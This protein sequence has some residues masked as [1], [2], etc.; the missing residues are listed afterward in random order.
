MPGRSRQFT[1][2]CFLKTRWFFINKGVSG[3]RVPDL[4]VRYMEDFL[5]LE[6][7]FISILIGINDVWRRYE[8][9]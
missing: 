8:R 5:D 4:I 3:N 9:E 1:T 6:P 7:D 2:R